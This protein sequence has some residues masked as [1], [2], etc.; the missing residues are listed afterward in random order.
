MNI[1]ILGISII[2]LIA[3]TYFLTKDIKHHKRPHKAFCVQEVLTPQE[4]AI[5]E[6]FDALLGITEMNNL[7]ESKK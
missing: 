4:N 7:K 3:C 5:A 1:K 6:R 2:F